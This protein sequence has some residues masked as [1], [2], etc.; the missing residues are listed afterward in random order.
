MVELHE[1]SQQEAERVMVSNALELGANAVLAIRFQVV[2]PSSA[3]YSV[4][5]YGTAVKLD[6]VDKPDG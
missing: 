2:A 6:S 4:M 5:C 3:L 1:S